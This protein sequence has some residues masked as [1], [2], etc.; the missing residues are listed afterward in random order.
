VFQLKH[1][2]GKD[3]KDALTWTWS[4][5]AATALADFGNPV[6]GSTEYT[7]CIYDSAPHLI[8]TIPGGGTCSGKPC[9]TATK[10]GF[11]YNSKDLALDGI[12][13]LQLTAGVAG[14]AKIKVTGKGEKLVLPTLPLTQAPTVTVQLTNTNG[15][16]WEAAFSAP[17]SK[18]NTT[19]FNDKSD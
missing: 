19:Q 4:K 6:S 14:K 2:T 13:Q 1:L 17:A 18:D 8:A 5:G 16:C 10:T 11:K 3:A 15:V 7:L 12:Q 9:W